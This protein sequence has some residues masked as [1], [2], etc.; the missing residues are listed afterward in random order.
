[1]AFIH[2]NINRQDYM[3][4]SLGLDHYTRNYWITGTLCKYPP[5]D[6]ELQLT[7]TYIIRNIPTWMNNIN[8]SVTNNQCNCKMLNSLING[9]SSWRSS[10][11]SVLHECPV[12]QSYHNPFSK[13]G[14]SVK[15]T[16]LS[17]SNLVGWMD[18]DTCTHV[19]TERDRE[20]W[21][22]VIVIG[23]AMCVRIL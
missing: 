5:D 18:P 11:N 15:H 17:T 10:F 21:K 9:K 7:C 8:R 19:C 3:Y 4:D 2:G 6:K 13:N 16:W 23:H 22:P 1:M 14:C 20:R 12:A